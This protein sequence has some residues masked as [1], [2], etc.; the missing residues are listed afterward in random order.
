MP[1]P[2]FRFFSPLFLPTL[3]FLA[4]SPG[5]VQSSEPGSVLRA[6]A[7]QERRAPSK[8]LLGEATPAGVRETVVPLFFQSA[9]GQTIGKIRAEVRV[10]Q[11]WG[12]F[13]RVDLPKNA[14][15]KASVKRRTEKSADQRSSSTVLEVTISAGSRAI[16]DGLLGHLRFSGQQSG[17]LPLPVV[18]KLETWPPEPEPVSRGPNE[19][20]FPMPADPPLNPGLSCFFFTH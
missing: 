12:Q 9:P 7:A 3:L 1:K 17:E 16:P 14:V 2:L 20:P 19:E 6:Q 8:L 10:P 4:P 18:G 5:L 13:R 15:W 11:G